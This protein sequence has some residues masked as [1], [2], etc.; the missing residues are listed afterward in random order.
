MPVNNT[1]PQAPVTQQTDIEFRGPNNS[2]SYNKRIQNNYTDLTVLYNR[3]N[4]AEQQNTEAFSR[5]YKDQLNIQQTLLDLE[6][7]ITAL[8]NTSTSLK[9]S[10][11][12]QVDTA[13]FAN[14]SFAIPTG[15]QLT[16][17][18]LHGLLTLPQIPAASVSKLAFVDPQTG[19]ITLPSSLAT[20]VIGINGSA[21]DINTNTISTSPPELAVARQVGRIW[22][23]NIICTS[24]NGVGSQMA[25]YIRAPQE[26]FT[27]ANANTIVLHPFPALGTDILEVAY[28]TNTAPI[29]DDSDGYQTLPQMHVDDMN[30]VGWVP[31]GTFGDGSDTDLNAGFRAYYFDPVPITALRIKLGQ[32]NYYQE[33]NNFIYSYGASLIDLLYTKFIS[34]GSL[35][36][37]F[38]A[39]SGKT[40]SNLTSIQPLLYNVIED[41]IPNVFTY[42]AIWETSYNSGIY[43]TNPVPFSKRVWIQVNLAVTSN[44][45]SPALSGLSLAYT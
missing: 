45:G 44:G 12:D 31:P 40:I 5:F 15:N 36:I 41:E 16:Q 11:F 37:R 39:P 13:R 20:N 10:N 14:T 35:I 38:D 19:V 3:V 28:S 23:R 29:M 22:Q 34:S 1:T 21:D 8:E 4:L 33:N 18:S 25:L 42:Q 7:R 32:R 24:P 30:A 2:S 27:T 9:F 26:I 17:D 6:N 43:T